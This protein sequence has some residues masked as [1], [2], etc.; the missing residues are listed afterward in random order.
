M[1]T[2]TFSYILTTR[3]YWECSLEKYKE[4]TGEIPLAPAPMGKCLETIR[5]CEH[6]GRTIVSGQ[7]STTL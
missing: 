7:K 2:F 6:P 4:M 3:L 5:L 1:F